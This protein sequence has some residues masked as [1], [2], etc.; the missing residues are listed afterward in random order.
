MGSIPVST[1]ETEAGKK[2]DGGV[3]RKAKRWKEKNEEIECKQKI[4]TKCVKCTMEK[5]M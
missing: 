4:E 5:P 1:C 3:K 2:E